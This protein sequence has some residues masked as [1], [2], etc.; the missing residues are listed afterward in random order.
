[1]DRPE[2]YA[3]MTLLINFIMDFIILWATAR[4]ARTTP[5]LS[6]IGVA[7]FLGGLYAVGYLLPFLQGFY[8]F[9]AKILFS[10]LMLLIA[11]PLDS[12]ELFKRAFVFFYAINFMVAGASIACS[13]MVQAYNLN[14][15]YLWLGAGILSA[16]LIGIFGGKWISQRI[17]PGLLKF[18]VEMVFDQK[19]CSG[20]GFLDTGNN[21][22]DPLTNKP[23][24]V[25]EYDLLK[26]CLP[27]DVKEA[28]KRNHDEG[29]LLDDLIECSWSRRLRL[30]PF[31]S[32]GKE[33]GMLVGIRADE[34]KVDL[35]HN[36]PSYKNM[37]VGIYQGKLSTHNHYQ[38]LIPA[39]IVEGG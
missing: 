26:E 15:H 36:Y 2:V 16:L 8:T 13:Y 23:V 10:C 20:K 1:M 32:I 5:V 31:T 11:L 17:I 39:E 21:L 9:P 14:S 24:I 27:E 33:H 38:M 37:V 19:S 28:I 7:A 18:K 4:M 12:W 34:V 30:I 6:R 3:D 35:G 22:R 25:A 29:Q